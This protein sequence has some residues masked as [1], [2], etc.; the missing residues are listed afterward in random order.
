MTVVVGTAGHIDHGKTSL[1]RALTGIDA[2]RLP[3]ERSRG[4]TIDVGFAHLTL[5]DG[6]ELDFVDVPGHDRLV[7]NMLVG[8]GEIDAALVVVAADDGPRPQTI[9][10]LALLDALGLRHGV[11][12]VTKTDLVEGDR[13]RAVAD[14]VGRLLEGTTLAGSP[15]VP[16]SS[17]TGAGREI[18]LEALVA[19]R[20]RV[21]AHDGRRPSTVALAVDR[22]FSVT[23]HG[24]VV[25]GTIRGGPVESGTV[26]RTVPGGED[27]R[28]RGLQVHGRRIERMDGG[29]RVALNLANRPASLRRGVVLT[30]DPAVVETDRS[31]VL[32]AR[33]VPDRTRSRLHLGTDAVD[34]S[35]GRAGRDA[36]D[37]DVGAL[38]VLRTAAPI[39]ARTGDRFVLRQPP[40]GAIVGG[41]VLD[42]RPARGMSR[43][44][45]TPARASALAAAV[46]GGDDPA[47]AAA[48]L[49]LH[50]VTSGSEGVRLADDVRDA[51]ATEAIGSVV[52]HH[53][54][55]PADTGL[56]LE[57]LRAIAARSIRRLVTASPEVGVRAAT[58][59]IAAL[60]ADGH[61]VR[62]GDRVR[63]P[64]HVPPPEDPA[65]T[66]AAD[67]LV[68]AL[69]T[70]AP[71]SLAAAARSAGCDTAT[72]R[73]LERDGRIVVIA[74]DV[75]Y[76]M[77]TYQALAAT[78]LAL[79]R[80]GPLSPAA[81]RDAT[82]T[83]RK[84]TMPILEDLGRRGILTRTPSGHV[85][86]PRAPVS[87]AGAR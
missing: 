5:P 73:A 25:T 27:V 70:N 37:L 79:A 87:P 68:A 34:V 44:R 45:Q 9:E 86:G 8:A 2:D 77:T 83:S 19:L 61:L 28:V 24:T 58:D 40:P 13:V 47:I 14:E 7:G 32:L 62:E 65:V 10:H 64:D 49:D 50:G 3:E 51:A 22:V 56:R 66:A 75:A 21:L 81:F 55:H 82:G 52:A 29:G 74:P 38:A 16:V 54:N 15:I 78:A 1:L 12:A 63:H 80:T 46:E 41:I 30:D 85:P 76:A 4:M 42:P 53:A 35:V 31:L 72:V 69:S 39:A 33:A 48:L 59:L 57:R 17:T 18:L 26:L 60:V 84:Y 11:V 36:I 23:G 67:R 6:T 43:R 20:D 71:P